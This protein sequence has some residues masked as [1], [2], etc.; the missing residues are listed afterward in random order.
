MFINKIKSAL[1]NNKGIYIIIVLT[2]VLSI[3]IFALLLHSPS[4]TPANV[5]SIAISPTPVDLESNYSNLNKVFP[6]KT[7]LKETEDING[8]PSSSSRDNEKT[9]LYYKTPIEGRVNKVVLEKNKTSYSIEH[10][11]GDYRGNVSNFK[12]THGEP[13][14]SLFDKQDNYS[15]SVY[16]KQGIGIKNDGKD[17][18]AIIYFIPQSKIEFMN[19]IAK[20]IG[21][22]ETPQIEQ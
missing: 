16:L 13:E 20:D 3:L 17:I 14:L 22:V 10:V 12:S 7:T 8:K 5:T 18:G 21:I 11:F 19:T 1:E 6:G 2:I 4:P 9:T 15:W